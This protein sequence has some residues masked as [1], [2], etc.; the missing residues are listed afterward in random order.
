M[1]NQSLTGMRVIELGTMLAAPF[2]AHILSQ[3]GAEVIKVEPPR[4]D[5][6]RSLVR[7][8]PSGTFIAY[9]HGK[10]SACIDL[11]HKDGYA[12]F[13]ELLK[14]ADILVHNLAPAAARKLGVSHNDC[15]RINP[16][17][18]Y[19]HIRG[20]AAGPQENDLASNPVAE[21]ATGVMEA[22]IVDGRPS[23]LGPSYHDQFAGVYAVVG[24]VAELLKKK[25]GQPAEAV[26]IGL[27]ET[28]LHVAARDLVGV[29]LKTQLLGR[30]EREPH[31]EF[32][33]PGYGAYLTADDRW[34]YLLMLT[35]G[36]WQ[37][38]CEAMHLPE[39]NDRSLITLRDRKKR[40][41]EVDGIVKD[42]IRAH[43][44]DDAVA[45]LNTAG[46]GCT[47]VLP[48]ERVLD[49]EHA[50]YPGKLRSVGMR[51]LEFNVPEFPRYDSSVDD[52][53]TLPPPELGA[54]TVELL[55]SGG[56]DSER[57][58][59]LLDAGAVYAENPERFTWAPVREK[60]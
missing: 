51:G 43:N 19:C 26:E 12:A 46:V 58:K 54:H 49:A 28:G 50:Q 25:Q 18:V 56:I 27:Y 41:A 10:K 39:A 55:Q 20:Y 59:A 29:Q 52:S 15:Q 47:E 21:A 14:T 5:P 37:K 8:G 48:I 6:T 53:T 22:N 23:R 3:M 33:M 2:A 24:I 13:C 60:A 11:K 7:G 30:P 40:H 1:L 45:M 35:D 36:H 16:D 4:G 32:S 42:A 38:F 34:L 44:Y 17:L 57:C 9:S 31:G